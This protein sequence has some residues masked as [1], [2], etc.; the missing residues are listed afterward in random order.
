MASTSGPALSSNSLI[1]PLP[2]TPYGP[3]TATDSSARAA[4]S[5][6]T[7]SPFSSTP[8]SNSTTISPAAASMPAFTA[9]AKPRVGNSGTKRKRSAARPS[10]QEAIRTSSE[11][12]TIS[13]SKS[14]LQCE[15]TERSQ[16]SASGLHP[17]TTVSRVTAR[18][19]A[20]CCWGGALIA[21]S[22]LPVGLSTTSH[23]PE[24]SCSRIASA[25]SNSFDCRRWIRSARSL[26]ASVR[27]VLLGFDRSRERRHYLERVTHHTEVR[28]LH[29]RRLGVLVDGDD[30]LGSLHANG[31]LHRAGDADG[32]V[33][34]RPHRLA[35]LADLH[36]IRHPTRV[37][38]RAA[39][40]DSP[41]QRARQVFE[42]REVLRPAEPAAAADDH[43]GVLELH[44]LS[45]LGHAL[46][47]AGPLGAFRHHHVELSDLG[48]AS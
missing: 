43:L 38:H 8:G 41:A 40:T 16:R 23:P 3:A 4:I 47:D 42:Q 5:R 36:R 6:V 2:R 14:A 19:G 29:D 31:V 20:T 12:S 34:A 24:W 26:S 28:H 45:G 22:S 39:S 18:G 30:H 17:W 48:R 25:A 1:V 44:L 32:D 9:A 46:G 21:C 10:N 7:A 13:A 33:D 35:G 11:L 15:N 37:D 27:S